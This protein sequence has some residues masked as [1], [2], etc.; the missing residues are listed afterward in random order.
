MANVARHTITRRLRLKTTARL[1]QRQGYAA[2][3]LN[4][5]LAES[6]APKGSLY[7]HFPGGKE[8]LAAE[9]IT[10]SGTRAGEQMAA[11]VSAAEDPAAAFSGLASL[12][13]A[14]LSESGFHDGCPVATV[15]LEAAADSEAI[16]SCCESVY[17]TWAEGLSVALERW[18]VA[19]QDCLPVSE[20]AIS[21]LQG[22]ILLAKI[23]R[24]PTVLH[25][26]ARQLACQ[27]SR[28]IQAQ[29]P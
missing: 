24:D 22:A 3:G 28:S 25:S 16:R 18:G 4:Q 23:R 5:V 19:P 12:F 14:N 6:G 11:I 13:A 26:V 20:L 17:G 21:A 7:F 2:T 9:S 29:R 10:I 15:A 1:F 27:I 8:Q